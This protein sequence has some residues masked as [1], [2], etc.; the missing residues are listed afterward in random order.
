MHV[1]ETLRHR[2]TLGI[3]TQKAIEDRLRVLLK[4]QII[5]RYM[6]TKVELHR[7][8]ESCT[9]IWES[10][11]VACSF[12]LTTLTRPLIDFTGDLRAEDQLRTIPTLP[13][14]D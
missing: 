10:P 14:W 9:K 5:H 2:F 8:L 4:H 12:I 3:A 1:T 13:P 7:S 11:D 6:T